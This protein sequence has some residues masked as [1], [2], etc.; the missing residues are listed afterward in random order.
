MAPDR[1]GSEHNMHAPA[2]HPKV[3]KTLGKLQEIGIA[4]TP[5]EVVWLAQLA[6]AFDATGPRVSRGGNS[7]EPVTLADLTLYPLTLLGDTWLARWFC[8]FDGWPARQTAIFLLAHLHSE[9]GDTTLRNY[10]DYEKLADLADNWLPSLPITQEQLDTAVEVLSRP[11][12]SD[13]SAPMVP[14]EKAAA[15]TE[16]ADPGDPDGAGMMARILSTFG[17]DADYW[18]TRRPVAYIA[19]MFEIHAADTADT[20][21]AAGEAPDLASPATKAAHNYLT[22]VKWIIYNHQPPKANPAP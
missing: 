1:K 19:A 12:V 13:T 7:P 22:A 17:G 10:T 8:R 4:P 15:A 16:E 5:A 9:P 20:T 11:F 18:E 2:L 14:P 3:S 6:T 21:T